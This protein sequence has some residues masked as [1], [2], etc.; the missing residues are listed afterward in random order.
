MFSFLLK[1]NHSNS[2]SLKLN[3]K[4]TILKIIP[5]AS[6]ISYLYLGVIMKLVGPLNLEMI[7]YRLVN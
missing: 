7:N 6:L 1:A 5:N 4:N 2:S 3:K